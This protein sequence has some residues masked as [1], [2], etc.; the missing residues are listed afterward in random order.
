MRRG[1][2][3]VDDWVAI[4]LP[5]AALPKHLRPSDLLDDCVIPPSKVAEKVVA[6][7][8]LV[9]SGGRPEPLT[10]RIV[11]SRHVAEFFTPRLRGDTME[12]IWIVGLDAKNRVR[13]TH[14]S[15]RGGSTSCAVSPADLIR[16]LVINACVG[17][18]MVHNHPSGD[19]RPS[20][21]DAALTERVRRGAELLGIKLLDHII[22]G[23][24]GYFS[25]LDA[26][27]LAP[28]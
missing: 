20:T 24:E 8:K 21:E 15:A 19:P 3:E 14:P 4:L 23:W 9:K 18:I 28:P 12:S 27:M 13:L 5:R 22:I 17:A 2:S 7:R 16:P 25:F 6:L 10:D 11:S 1:P 26:G